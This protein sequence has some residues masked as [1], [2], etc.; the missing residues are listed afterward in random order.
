MVRGAL[1]VREA[2]GA[3]DGQLGG[4]TGNITVERKEGGHRKGTRED[5][6]CLTLEG[7]VGWVGWVGWIVL[8]VYPYCMKEWKGKDAMKAKMVWIGR[9]VEMDCRTVLREIES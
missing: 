9:T 6:R 1:F 3:A 4:G 5:A 8:T 2:L 7:Q